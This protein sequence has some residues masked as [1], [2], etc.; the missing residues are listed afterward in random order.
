MGLSEHS[1]RE[2]KWIR[3]GN[4]LGRRCGL[5]RGVCRPSGIGDFSPK[6]R[7]LERKIDD[8][9][10]A[11]KRSCGTPPLSSP[12]LVSLQLMPERKR[13]KGVSDNSS[14]NIIDGVYF[15]F[16]FAKGMCKGR[17]IK[18]ECPVRHKNYAI[19]DYQIFCN[20]HIANF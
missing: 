20:Y 1:R 18:D 13:D 2:L 15:T 8:R 7:N 3:I 12:S 16:S 10:W 14:K 6:I 19:H 9:S 5:W 4:E 17:K 11:D